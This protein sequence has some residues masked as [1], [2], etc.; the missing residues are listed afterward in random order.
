MKKVLINNQGQGLIEL[1]I[2]I[3]VIVV[4]LFA[5]WTLFMS[6]FNGEQEAKARVIG[7]NLSREGI[8]AVKNIRDSNWLHRDE[9]QLDELNNLWAWDHSL[10]PGYYTIDELFS[11]PN[12]D[13]DGLVKLKTI[14]FPAEAD[15]SKLYINDLGFFVHESGSRFS[16]Y[17]RLITIKNI[18][19]NSNK[20]DGET[21]ENKI[22]QQCADQDF[23]LADGGCDSAFGADYTKIGISVICQVDWKVNEKPRKIVIEDQ[24]FNWR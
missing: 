24:L 21:D 23:K 2:A 7:A 22:R 15:K 19:C 12:P 11:S 6:N 1:I 17:S 9:N 4:G 20:D 14:A 18:C 5:V 3:A 10:V 13:Y 16:G 8:E